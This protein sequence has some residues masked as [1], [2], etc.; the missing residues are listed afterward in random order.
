MENWKPIE[1]YEGLYEVSDQGRVRNVKRGRLLS[2]C[3]VTHGYLAYGLSKGGK[4]RSLLAHRLVAKAFILNP[5]NKP[6]V[7]HIDG[8]KSHNFVSNLEWATAEENLWH[9]ERI[10]LKPTYPAKLKKSPESN[11]NYTASLWHSNLKALREDKGLTPEELAEA[12][13]VRLS[14]IAS[15][16]NG[17]KGFREV[18]VATAS[19]LAWALGVSIDALFTYDVAEAIRKEKAWH[20]KEKRKEA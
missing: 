10:G 7:N 5:E 20:D 17:S 14:T 1:G 8:V 18:S 9:A 19:K 11:P 4:T 6:Q 16:E 2:A 3:K 15:L 12:C 13:C